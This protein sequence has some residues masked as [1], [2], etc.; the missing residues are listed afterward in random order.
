MHAAPYRPPP[1]WAIVLG[2]ALIYTSWG[3]TYLPMRI[4]VHDEHIPPLLFGGSRVAIA[5][6]LLLAYQAVRGASLRIGKGEFLA[7]AGVSWLLFVGGNGLMNAANKSVT[8]SVCAVLA[9]TTPLWLGFLAMLWPHGDRLTPRGWL[10]LVVG[11][12]GV[13]VLLQERYQENDGDL[14]RDVGPLLALGSAAAWALGSLV[15]RQFHPR[16]PH[17]TAAAYQMIVGGL[18]LSLLG[19][20]LGEPAQFPDR[21]TPTALSAFLYLLIV[22]SLVGF[23]SFNWLLK[24]VSAAKVGTYAYVN[25]AVAVVVGCLLGNE[26]FTPHLATGIAIILLGVFLVRGG[27]RPPLAS[28]ELEPVQPDPDD[29]SAAGARVAP[30]VRASSVGRE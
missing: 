16:T 15:L 14:F 7:I 21:L 13:V 1:T 4:G 9:A 20:A 12:A 6:T 18:S 2:F 24:H 8:S 27:E 26:P 30:V 5:G 19:V 17:L 10:G 23:V 3:T 11:L 22:G 28:V 25:P 29:T